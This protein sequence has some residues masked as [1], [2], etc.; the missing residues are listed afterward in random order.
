MRIAIWVLVVCL[1]L[2]TV[3]AAKK[4]KGKGKGKPSK[5]TKPK[6]AVEEPTGSGS[7]PEE[8]V[9][10]GKPGKGGKPEGCGKGKTPCKCEDMDR[11][12]KGKG[13]PSKGK[14]KPSKPSEVTIPEICC[15]DDGEGSGPGGEMPEPRG[16]CI[17]EEKVGAICMAGSS[18]ME[19]AL[20]SWDVC[21]DQCEG[22]M[23]SSGLLDMRAKKPKGKGKGKGKPSKGKPSKCASVS[24][25]MDE[26]AD[27]YS[28]EI[29]HFT[30]MGWLDSDMVADEDLIMEDIMTL[31]SEISD[32]LNGEAYEECIANMETK[33]AKPYTKCMKEYSEEEQADLYEVFNG[34][35]HTECFAAM[36]EE[37]CGAYME[38]TIAAMAGLGNYGSG[39]GSGSE[40]GSGSDF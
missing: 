17:D 13:K 35:A 4:P 29:C 2:A 8:G 6:P 5:P 20:A 26:T 15:C 21:A 24:K 37:G 39:S 3:E 31:P 12:G 32:A 16:F 34:V 40:S 22:Y 25:I 23:R 33:A 14:G 38:N 19:K 30:A 9:T 7:E 18:I 28:C 10:S 11:K 27:K 1:A 36:F